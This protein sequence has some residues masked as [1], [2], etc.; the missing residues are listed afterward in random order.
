MT[1]QHPVQISPGQW[2][3]HT[4]CKKPSWTPEQHIMKKN[5]KA[6][7]LMF[8]CI[9]FCCV[10]LNSSGILRAVFFRLQRL[11]HSSQMPADPT[12]DSS[13]TR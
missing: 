3:I 1:L 13:P 10:K 6:S 7:H 8:R 9:M 11:S 4:L 5:L 2:R 12:H